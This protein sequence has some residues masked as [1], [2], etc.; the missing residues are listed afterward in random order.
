M[1]ENTGYVVAPTE[2]CP[3]QDTPSAIGCTVVVGRC[4]GCRSN[5]SR[6]VLEQAQRVERRTYW[7]PT[8]GH[9]VSLDG[10]V[11]RLAREVVSWVP[12]DT[13]EQP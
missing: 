9:H 5:G 13:E 2:T 6:A 3:Q 12:V 10:S 8:T 1:T 11:R 4:L 7:E